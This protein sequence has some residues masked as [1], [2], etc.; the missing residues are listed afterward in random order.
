MDIKR[1]PLWNRHLSLP[2]YLSDPRDNPM[3]HRMHNGLLPNERLHQHPLRK[4]CTRYRSSSNGS[5]RRKT[6]V[7][8]AILL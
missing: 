7:T 2:A 3:K 4:N 1:L 8:E 5:S 6:P